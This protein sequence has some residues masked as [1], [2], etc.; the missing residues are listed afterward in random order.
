MEI[1]KFKQNFLMIVNTNNDLYCLK[2]NEI[3]SKIREQNTEN[4]ARYLNIKY[5]STLD[6]NFM[7]LAPRYYLDRGK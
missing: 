5:R 1:I 6:E 4:E 2:L 7:E 3:K